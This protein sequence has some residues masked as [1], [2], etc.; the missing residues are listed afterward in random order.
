MYIVGYTDPNGNY[1]LDH[2]FLFYQTVEK[3]KC[4]IEDK[5][6]NP[7]IT[8]SELCQE[9]ESATTAMLDAASHIISKHLIKDGIVD[10]N[11]HFFSLNYLLFKSVGSI[12]QLK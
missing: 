5:T 9:I 6:D 7:S 1:I 4:W 10:I 2:V 8:Y 12:L 3:S 11:K